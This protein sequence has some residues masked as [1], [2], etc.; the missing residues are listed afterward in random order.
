MKARL[1]E[2][3]RRILANQIQIMDALAEFVPETSESV[4]KSLVEAANET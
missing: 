1:M 4:T 2:A 3:E